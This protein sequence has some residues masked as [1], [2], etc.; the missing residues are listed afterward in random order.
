MAVI[1][2]IPKERFF[3]K[4]QKKKV[5]NKVARFITINNCFETGSMTRILEKQNP[6]VSLSRIV[7]K[8]VD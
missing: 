8:T 7:G 1:F 6:Y 3:K 4:K 2:G 5:K